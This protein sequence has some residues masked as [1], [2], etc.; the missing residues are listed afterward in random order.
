LPVPD[1]KVSGGKGDGKS[2]GNWGE[3]DRPAEE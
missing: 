3:A 2:K 1:A